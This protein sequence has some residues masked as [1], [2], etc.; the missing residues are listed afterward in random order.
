MWHRFVEQVDS[1][2][3]PCPDFYFRSTFDPSKQ[4]LEI[5]PSSKSATPSTMSPTEEVGVAMV[6][7]MKTALEDSIKAG[8]TLIVLWKV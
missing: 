7:D 6:T 2:A 8:L 4:S 1:A 3:S 5:P